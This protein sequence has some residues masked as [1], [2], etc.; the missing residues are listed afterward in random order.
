MPSDAAFEKCMSALQS[1]YGSTVVLDGGIVESVYYQAV[2]K[3]N[4]E[5]LEAAI[6]TCIKKNS[7]QF[8][9][10]PSA[11]QLLEYAGYDPERPPGEN[12]MA[13]Q[14]ANYLALRSS[15]MVADEMTQEQR[16]VMIQCMRLAAEKRNKKRFRNKGLVSIGEVIDPSIARQ[17]LLEDMRKYLN[18]GLD[19]LR[20]RAINWA[21]DPENGCEL[22]R[23]DG[24]VT[25]IREIDF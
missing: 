18:S 10:F 5:E 23:V 8:G 19:E 12:Y 9:Y 7:R 15:E 1:F 2:E 16:L 25:D 11:T 14:P 22:V 20:Q 4:D 17:S 24:R 6:A 3:L 13:Q 21:S